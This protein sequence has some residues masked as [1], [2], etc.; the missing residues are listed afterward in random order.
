MGDHSKIEWTDASWNP[1]VGCSRVSSGCDNCYAMNQAHRLA[2]MH[3]SGPYPGTTRKSKNGID[4]TGVVKCLPERLD[5]P[6]RWKRPRRIFVNSMSDLFHPTVPFEFID[7]VFAVMSLA[8]Q[9][10][11]QVLTKR[12]ERMAAYLTREGRQRSIAA[13]QHTVGVHLPL[14]DYPNWPL[15]NAWLGT[16][17]ED[18]VTADERIPHLLR[19]PAAVRWLS[20]EPLLEPIDLTPYFDNG[21]PDLIGYEE[22]L[23]WIVVGG[24][25]G[26]KAR[27]MHP[28]WA[29]SLQVQ[30]ETAG[31]PFFF[32]QWGRWIVPQQGELTLNEVRRSQYFPELDKR[33]VSVGKHA[34][35]RWL[36]GRTWNEYPSVT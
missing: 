19:C 24:E 30:C 10:T 23:H 26:P 28:A 5:Q 1:I 2:A 20:C 34:A 14:F 3:P 29:R 6:L 7:Q 36:D 8:P 35:G 11:F 4:W 16:S 12:P 31:V 15:P 21:E 17:V 18:Q 9:H 27:P 32:K 13:A 25:S 22:Y 33:F